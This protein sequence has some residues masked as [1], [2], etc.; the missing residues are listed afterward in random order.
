MPTQVVHLRTDARPRP[1]S[2]DRGTPTTPAPAPPWLAGNSVRQSRGYAERLTAQAATR[3]V[4]VERLRIAR[5]THDT[6][7]HSIG[8]IAL[9]AG[10]AARVTTTRPEAAREAMRAVEREG[11]GPA[12]DPGL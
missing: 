11:P 3:A 8:I 4:T 9:R 5:E 1:R 10:T 6:V 12:G 2:Y 7:A